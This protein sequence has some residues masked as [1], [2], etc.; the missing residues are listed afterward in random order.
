MVKTDW[1]VSADELLSLI[2]DAGFM[3]ALQKELTL[4]EEQVRQF[5]SQHL[6]RDYFPALLQNMTRYCTQNTRGMSS[7]EHA[8]GTCQDDNILENCCRIS[9]IVEFLYPFILI[10]EK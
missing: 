9:G 5:Y 6:E 3:V 8:Q 10:S 4:T 7:K 2:R 1:N